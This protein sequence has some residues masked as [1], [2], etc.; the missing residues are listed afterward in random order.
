MSSSG[1]SGGQQAQTFCGFCGYTDTQRFTFCPRCGRP[2]ATFGAQAGSSGADLNT[3]GTRP[4]ASETYGE[5]PTQPGTSPYENAG[6]WPYQPNQNT[7]PT[8]YQPYQGA[9]GP[10]AYQNAGRWPYQPNQGAGSAPN[11]ERQGAGGPPPGYVLPPA[12]QTGPYIP[13]G[14]FPQGGAFASGPPNGQGAT[15]APAKRPWSR[16]KRLSVIGGALLALLIVG[17]AAAYFVYTA[18]FAYSPTDSARYLP[19][20]TLFY[21]SIDLQQIA[22]NPHQVSQSDIAQTTNTSGFEQSTGLDFQKDV[23]PWVKRSLSFAVVDMTSQPATGGAGQPTSSGTV[24]LISTHDTSASNATLQKIITIQQQKY[25]VKFTSISYGGVTLQS[26]VDSAQ[27]QQGNANGSASPLV[28]GIVK[29]QV[30]IASTVAVAE[31]VVDRV[32][33]TGTTLAQ[34]TTFTDAI[35]K[36]PSDRFGT[37]Y[38]NVKQLLSDELHL[39][40]S[41]QSSLT[42]S[43][44]VGYGSLQFTTAGLRLS[45]TLEAKAGTQVKYHLAGDTNAS[46][47][48]VPASTILYAG[49]GNLSAFYDQA[50][51]ESA[52][53]ITNGNVQSMLGVSPDDPLLQSPV[54]LALLPPTAGSDNVVDPLVILH[55]SEDAATANATVQQAIQSLGYQ[56]ETSTLSGVTVTT[57]QAS[58][59]TISYATLG[60]DLVFASDTDGLSQAIGVFQGH[61]PSLA[62]SS[63]FQ[64]AVSNGARTNALTLFVSLSN[65][66]SAPGSLGDSYRQFVKQNTG[67]IA[68]VTTSY[69][70]YN[71]DNTGITITEDIALK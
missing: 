50:R 63:A 62:Q 28:L 6:R 27:N 30:I 68:R 33:G 52:G 23:A 46:A 18:F 53:A 14:V 55:F 57:I 20:T 45:F 10:Q 51:D 24:Y 7:G 48:V 9:G 36:L 69:L 42:D 67:L 25:S 65:L 41:S 31:Q 19:A 59:Q 37:L 26:D 43:Y 47:G 38:V 21:S 61:Q 12:G 44:P 29:D 70:T 56:T 49:V 13:G 16:G 60:H 1:D 71:S 5:A 40:A 32:N 39:G 17:S 3:A 11:Q 64:Q 15:I 58:G 2:G 35:N 66:A 4:G 54:S 22:Q 8:P 34:N